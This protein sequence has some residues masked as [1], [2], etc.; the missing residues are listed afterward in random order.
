MGLN[1]KRGIVYNTI[2]DSAWRSEGKSCQP[3]V[4]LDPEKYTAWLRRIRTLRD[5][6][7]LMLLGVS[8]FPAG[9]GQ[10]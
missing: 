8:P 1:E 6:R 4:L 3:E 7:V 5:G 10:P 2:G 9:D